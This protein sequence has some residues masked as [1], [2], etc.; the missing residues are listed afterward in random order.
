MSDDRPDPAT[1]TS[2]GE[3]GPSTDGTGAGDAG[4]DPRGSRGVE[5]D[6]REMTDSPADTLPHKS[7]PDGPADRRTT[8]ELPGPDPGQRPHPGA[9]RNKQGI[10]VDP[11]ADAEP[12]NREATLSALVE[13]EP[14][15]L[16]R[17]SG[18]FSRRQFNIES[19][20]VGP[21]KTDEFARITLV[22]DEEE[23][24]VRQARKQL[25]KLK[26]VVSVRWLKEDA[27]HRELAL[28]KVDGAS[29]DQVAAVADM[30]GA[31]TVDADRHTVTVEITGAEPKIESAIETFGRF[32]VREITR[33]GT[34]AL[35]RGGTPTADYEAAA[36]RTAEPGEPGDAAA[37]TD[38]GRGHPWTGLTAGTDGTRA[39]PTATEPAEG[40]NDD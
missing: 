35:E 39:E 16:S 8:G 20:T 29:P 3:G 33:T 38:G 23:P 22:I 34:A 10:R 14:G 4:A 26:P 2:D 7:G 30:Y 18:L 13:H 17:V 31:K 15:V 9:R 21:T 24:D 37:A 27:I 11:D 40:G 25:E 28:I 1:R 5:P 6:T 12:P 32:G 36:A 19:L